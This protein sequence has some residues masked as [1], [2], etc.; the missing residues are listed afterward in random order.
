MKFINFLKLKLLEN[1]QSN[2]KFNKNRRFNI[3]LQTFLSQSLKFVYRKVNITTHKMFTHK[4]AFSSDSAKTKL[5]FY[6]VIKKQSVV[7]RSPERNEAS[8]KFL[9][10]FFTRR[11]SK[12]GHFCVLFIVTKWCLWL[13]YVA[14]IKIVFCHRKWCASVFFFLKFIYY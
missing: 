2:S 3:N 12:F 10:C 9:L 6:D 13:A 8:W 5:N 4:A 1:E 7:V 14:N 11:H